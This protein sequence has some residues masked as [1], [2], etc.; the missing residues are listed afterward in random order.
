MPLYMDRHDLHEES[1]ADVAN[2]HARD[3]EVQEAYGVSFLSYWFDE[4]SGSAFCLAR[5]PGAE[6]METVHRESHGLVP[7]EIIPVSED[8]VRQFLGVVRN[9]A[10]ESEVTSAIR[11]IL[12]TDIEGST[13]LAEKLEQ[14][15]FIELLNEHDRIVRK[16][17]LASRG[18]EIK[19][20]GDGIMA[21]FDEVSDAL[22]AALAIREGFQSRNA[23][24]LTPL[25]VRIGLASGEP[26]DRDGDLFGPTVNLA[27]RLCAAS[28]PGSVLVSEGVHEAGS[29]QG[30]A[31]TE[32]DRR[33]LK[34]FAEPVRAFEFRGAISDQEN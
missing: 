30:F 31:F 34:G 27:N 7:N 26:V 8:A 17:L 18:R 5:A 23:A 15:E 28:A 11:T 4:E 22:D 21:S 12:F 32:V 19:H 20:T 14:A 10:D 1:A 3:L 33:Q 9:P 24:A 25:G 13:A 16:A 6:D 2:A 29:S